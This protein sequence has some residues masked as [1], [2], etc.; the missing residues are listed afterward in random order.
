ME[1]TEEARQERWKQYKIEMDMDMDI[2]CPDNFNS[3]DNVFPFPVLNDIAY[4]RMMFKLENGE[5]YVK[6][7]YGVCKDR[8]NCKCKFNLNFLDKDGMMVRV[9]NGKTLPVFYE[10]F[11]RNR[12]NNK[13]K[14]WCEVGEHYV[15]IEDH[16]SRNNYPTCGD[17][18]ECSKESEI[19]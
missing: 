3:K 9:V 17:C 16:W 7:Y 5:R 12:S 2:E 4:N 14:E 10:S 15:D 11:I 18:M 8:N 13:Y 1:N 19:I 6:S